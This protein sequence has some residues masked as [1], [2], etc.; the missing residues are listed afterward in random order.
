M[1]ICTLWITFLLWQAWTS[2]RWS[3]SESQISMIES[4]EESM[5]MRKD[6]RTAEK[7]AIVHQRILSLESLRGNEEIV[8]WFL[9]H[10]KAIVQKMD[11]TLP[12]IENKIVVETENKPLLPVRTIEIL[13]VNED[14]PGD[15]RV[16]SAPNIWADIIGKLSTWESKQILY[17]NEDNRYKISYDGYAWRV[18]CWYVDVS[19]KDLYIDQ[20]DPIAKVL[21]ETSD[22]EDDIN[23]NTNS[24]VIMSTDTLTPDDAYTTFSLNEFVD[25]RYPKVHAWT[26][27]NGV[28]EACMKYYNTIDAVAREKDFPTALVI[29]TWY[30]EFDCR[31][32]NPSNTRWPF[33]VTSSYKAPGPIT[34]DELKEQVAEFIDFSNAKYDYYTKLRKFDEIPV[35]L[36]HSHVDLV[37]IQKHSILYNGMYSWVTPANSSYSNQNFWHWDSNIRDGIVAMFLKVE[38]ARK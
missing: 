22:N 17:E 12:V 19:T 33:Q 8:Q 10:S 9:I 1:L 30:R 29:A 36:S 2:A 23:K 11:D 31:L 13:T 6:K 4:V 34:T 18:A 7:S 37:S 28:P 38:Q 14:E 24:L 27:E 15:L 35:K 32:E 25:F 16:R 21:P 20:P 26:Q 5:L 3:P